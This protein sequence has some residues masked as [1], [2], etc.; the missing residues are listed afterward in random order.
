MRKILETLLKRKDVDKEMLEDITTDRELFYETC[1]DVYL[2]VDCN[3]E[4]YDDCREC[5]K[6]VLG[7]DKE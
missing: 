6:K 3:C 4:D 5:W 1:P 7:L 2:N